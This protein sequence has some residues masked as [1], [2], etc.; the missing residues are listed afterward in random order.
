[1]IALR[2]RP[3]WPFL[4]ALLAAPFVLTCGSSSGIKNGGD[5]PVAL[6]NQ[7][8][9]VYANL[10]FPDAGQAGTLAKGVCQTSCSSPSVMNSKSCSN[11]DQIAAAYKACL[12]KTTCAEVMSCNAS[13]PPCAGGNGAG[14]RN[15]GGTGGTTGAGVGGAIATGAGGSTGGTAC[16]DLAACCNATSNAQLKAACMTYYTTVAG[17]G[18]AACAQALQ[19]VK[20][21]YCP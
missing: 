20:G 3:A 17:M 10:C 11:G 13:V 6:C 16:A 4:L 1:M 9:D 19:A 15:G 21:T 7:T 18:D 8:C 2:S 5:D 12:D 14:G